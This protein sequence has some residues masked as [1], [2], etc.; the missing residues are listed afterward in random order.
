MNWQVDGDRNTSFFHKVTKIRQASKALSTIRDGDNILTS[1]AEIA[2]HTLAYFTQ[3]Y[4]SHNNASPSHLI[5]DVI[6]SLVSEEDNCMLSKWLVGVGDKVNFW[7]ENWLGAA[8]VD[9]M[10]ILASLHS[11][12]VA[13]VSDFVWNSTW[14][15]PKVFAE[16]FPDVV[17]D[18]VQVNI[19]RM[20]DKLIWQGTTNGTLS[21]KSTFIC[22]RPAIEERTWCKKIW[23]DFIPPSK[24]FTTWR[25]FHQKMPTDENLQLRGCQL[26]SM[27]SNCHSHIET[28]I[29]LFLEFP[30][31]VKLWDWRGGLFS[32]QF[33]ISSIDSI[34]SACNRQW[35]SQRAPYI[36]EVV[37][38]APMPGW[39]KINYDGTAKGAPDLAG[40]G[41]IFIDHNGTYLGELQAIIKAIQISHQKGWRTIWLECDS[42]LVVD[43][44]KGKG[45]I[46]WRLTWSCASI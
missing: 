40:G 13:R 35:S 17:Q 44:L 9:Q 2:Q 30:F 25:L 7:K 28:S 22:L 33:N 39:I 14:T 24:S 21:L 6:P 15:I 38:L 42:V 34:L 43:I 5:Q 1:Q 4:A 8:L 10:S 29:H 46:P 18:I 32:I 3:L 37:W 11:S 12:L 27:C 36:K 23:S 19:C 41:S 45:V 16:A 26:A 31:V 20:Q